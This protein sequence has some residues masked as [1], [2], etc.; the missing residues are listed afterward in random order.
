MLFPLKRRP[1]P[2][3]PWLTG[4]A[5]VDAAAEEEAGVTLAMTDAAIA[6][7]LEDCFFGLSATGAAI[8]LDGESSEDAGALEAGA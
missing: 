7:E 4:A 3:P 1:R 5:E 6:A 8:K 2:L